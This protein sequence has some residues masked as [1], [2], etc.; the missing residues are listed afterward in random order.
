MLLS[1]GAVPLDLAERKVDW[2]IAEE[3]ART[4][5]RPVR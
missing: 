3:K 4:A 2:F 5:G 1:S